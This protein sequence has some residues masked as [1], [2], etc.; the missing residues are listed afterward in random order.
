LDALVVFDPNRKLAAKVA[1]L[2]ELCVNGTTIAVGCMTRPIPAFNATSR[3]DHANVLIEVLAF[4]C[5]Y[6]DRAIITGSVRN[7]EARETIGFGSDFVGVVREVGGRV[8]S[9]KRGDR[10]IG[11]NSYPNAALREVLPG[12]PTN[13]ASLRFLVLHECKVAII[14]KSMPTQ[15]AAGFSIAAQTSYSMIRKMRVSPRDRCI[16][17]GASSNTGLFSLATLHNKG[18]ETYAITTGLKDF[19]NLNVTGTIRISPPDLSVG[20]NEVVKRLTREHGGVDF[21]IDCF[22]DVYATSVLPLLKAG[23][24]YVTCGIFAQRGTDPLVGPSGTKWRDVLVSLI[25][26]NISVYGNCL[27]R[28]ED[29][30]SAIRDYAE[31]SIPIPHDST[32]GIDDGVKF[33]S[34]SFVEPERFG[35]V[36]L[37][38]LPD[39]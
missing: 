23:G 22:S 26:N 3:E 16:V 33:L 6:R 32:Y 4:S 37:Q 35:K 15:V 18:V 10:V 38:Y 8:E 28:E 17:T 12:I 36:V 11:N 2:G 9:V 5:N 13:E 21:V 30:A 7:R 19:S 31:S 1:K 34:R 29:L 14:P 20:S 39:G 24:T 27:G 25:T